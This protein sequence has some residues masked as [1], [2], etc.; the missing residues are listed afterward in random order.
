MGRSEMMT[1]RILKSERKMA[2][3]TP[4]REAQVSTVLFQT[5]SQ[6]YG[7]LK[8]YCTLL[9]SLLHSKVF[10]TRKYIPRKCWLQD[11]YHTIN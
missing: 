9:H 11:I 10:Y 4:E 3:H 7:A 5:P 6:S 2:F 8:H 1:Y